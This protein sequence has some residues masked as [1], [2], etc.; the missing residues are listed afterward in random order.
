M[1]QQM[2]ALIPVLS[3]CWTGLIMSQATLCYLCGDFRQNLCEAT[4]G[5]FWVLLGAHAAVVDAVQTSVCFLLFC[6]LPRPLPAGICAI[7]ELQ[8]APA[9]CKAG[10]S[11]PLQALAVRR[12]SPSCTPGAA[13][14]HP[15]APSAAAVP[16]EALC[17]ALPC[18]SLPLC[19]LGSYDYACEGCCSVGGL[20]CRPGCRM[21]C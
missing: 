4:P 2:Q 14:P 3:A 8:A 5:C 19:G 1:L 13:P 11:R 9:S 6:C 18:D 10:T 21:W 15:G 17:L 20:L 7:R 12:H 16:G